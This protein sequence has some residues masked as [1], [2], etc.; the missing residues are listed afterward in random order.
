M[1]RSTFP[2]RFDSAG[3]SGTRLSFFAEDVLLI[4]LLLVQSS[5]EPFQ[6]VAERRA[7]I[8]DLSP[9]PAALFGEQHRVGGA[10]RAGSSF[11]LDQSRMDVLE[12][13]L[14]FIRGRIP[15]KTSAP[16]ETHLANG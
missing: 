12:C 14:V 4:V 1:R 13:T 9:T 5:S 2:G 7:G 15:S 10:V 11:L 8:L 3:N 16:Q 6:C